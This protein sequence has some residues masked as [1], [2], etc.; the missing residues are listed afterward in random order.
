MARG[1]GL[2]A[3]AVMAGACA[4]GDDGEAADQ[5]AEDPTP[6]GCPQAAAGLPAG[7]AGAV[8]QVNRIRRRAG[9]G[10]LEAI[11][12]MSEAAVRHCGYY[13]ASGGGPCV[14]RPHRE[15]PGCPGFVAPMFDERLE[16]AGYQGYARFEVMAYVADAPTSVRLWLDSVW[17]RL[18][19]LAPELQQ[20]GY[21]AARRGDLRCDTM[22]FGVAAGDRS[23][24]RVVTY[25]LDG[26]QGVPRSFSG[27]ESPE[28]PPPPQGWPSGYPITLYAAGLTATA[29]AITVDGRDQPL[30]HEFI[31]PGDPRAAGLLIDEMMLYTWRPLAPATRYRVRIEGTRGGEPVR[32]EWTFT[33]R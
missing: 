18:P 20:A 29:H 14:D 9:L 1:I 28:P 11:G 30:E 25:P 16:K 2:V 8:E 4:Q 12:E 21:G 26:Q 7:A 31:A 10:C 5:S 24:S 6:S 3:L 27:R 32:F 22:E 33:T 15:M 19:I 17:H 23:S 13:V